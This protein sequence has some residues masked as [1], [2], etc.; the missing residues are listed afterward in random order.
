MQDLQ[1]VL[2]ILGQSAATK[3]WTRLVK[4]LPR[5][6]ARVGGPPEQQAGLRKKI[7]EAAREPDAAKRTA[8]TCNGSAAEQESSSDRPSAWPAAWSG[9][10]PRRPAAPRAR[11]AEQM[12][13]AGQ[14]AAAGNAAAAGQKAA[15]AEKSLQ[16]ARRQLAQRRFQAQAELAMEQMARLEDALKHLQR[17]EQN[18]LEETRR[19][20]EIQ[21]AE[22]RLTAPRR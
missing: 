18:V 3:S 10:W 19:L 1:D 12:G 8:E 2:D 17:Q 6:R 13:Q 7:A 16:E 9:S 21:Q 11:P 22:G 15:A 5:G 20:E 4:K 14:Q